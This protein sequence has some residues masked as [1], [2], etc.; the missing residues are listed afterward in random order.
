MKL[1]YEGNFDQG[2]YKVKENGAEKIVHFSD[3]D[4]FNKRGI[5]YKDENTQLK[6][7]KLKSGTVRLYSEFIYNKEEYRSKY[8]TEISISDGMFMELKLKG[9]ITLL[10]T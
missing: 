5:T 10:D 1:K 6:A 4:A 3:V 9:V 2:V 8:Y 7:Q